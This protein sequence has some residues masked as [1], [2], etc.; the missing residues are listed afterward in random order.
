MATCPALF[1]DAGRTEEGPSHESRSDQHGIRGCKRPGP[2]G[3]EFTLNLARDFSPA[4]RF[5]EDVTYYAGLS[6]VLTRVSDLDSSTHIVTGCF[7]MK[8][9]MYTYMDFYF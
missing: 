1:T 4:Y 8:G 3:S 9:G 6:A 7:L 2:E 5:L